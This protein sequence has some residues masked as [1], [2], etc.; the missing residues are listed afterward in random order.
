[1][2]NKTICNGYWIGPH[3]IRVKNYVPYV[4]AK[5]G[6]NRVM[7]KDGQLIQYTGIKNTTE[8]TKNEYLNKFCYY[9]K[10]DGSYHYN[11]SLNHEHNIYV[12]IDSKNMPHFC[13]IHELIRQN[14]KLIKRYKDAEETNDDNCCIIS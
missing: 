2:S 10:D 11:A 14:N 8:L 9:D 4:P 5:D 1:M 7:P 13:N 12:F 6:V 3:N